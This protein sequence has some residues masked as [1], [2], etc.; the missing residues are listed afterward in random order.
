MRAAIYARILL[1]LFCLLA[2]ATSASAECAWVLWLWYA[3]TVEGTVAPIEAFESL[4]SCMSVAKARVSLLTPVQGQ[5][6]VQTNSMWEVLVARGGSTAVYS[7][8]C[9]PDT[10]APR[11][12]KG[13]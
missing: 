9:W 11:G 3:E 12:L 7:Y 2:L 13:K 8:Q 1:A 6:P 5:P 4:G 10:V